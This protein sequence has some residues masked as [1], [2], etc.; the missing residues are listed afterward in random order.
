ME[1]TIRL[2]YYFWPLEF[3]QRYYNS[4]N[5]QNHQFDFNEPSRNHYHVNGL[6]AVGDIYK[7]QPIR[8]ALFGESPTHQKELSMEKRWPELMRSHWGKNKVHVDNFSIGNISPI[9]ILR[10]LK[11]LKKLGIR[12]DLIFLSFNYSPK[13]PAN[14]ITYDA[15]WQPRK[16]LSLF[17]LLKKLFLDWKSKQNLNDFNQTDP[18]NIDWYKNKNQ[19]S[20]S[21]RELRQSLELK[22]LFIEKKPQTPKE[23]KDQFRKS[24]SEIIEVA[25]SMS[26]CV[27]WSPS[28]RIAYRDNMLTSYKARYMYLHPIYPLTV[29]RQYL[30]AKSLASLW[31]L[32][33]DQSTAIAMQMGLPVLDW[34]K[35]LVAQIDQEE[36]LFLD[37]FHISEKGAIW[38][39]KF[40]EERLLSNDS[41]F[42]MNSRESLEEPTGLKSK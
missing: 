25:H 16:G 20:I 5:Y 22:N 26:P 38:V 28:S 11:F 30:N 1:A 19:S 7:G 3:F 9:N 42:R 6:G 17:Y 41:C 21:S 36:D 40:L 29:P 10:E 24:L 23:Q 4:E 31:D 37:E 8:I 18:S 13:D 32:R 34:L 33:A 39:A 14:N 12:Y 35:V 15:R 27:I 2:A